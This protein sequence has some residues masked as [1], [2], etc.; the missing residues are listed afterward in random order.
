MD[1]PYGFKSRFS[2]HKDRLKN[3]S[4]LFYESVMGKQSDIN[5]GTDMQA[6]SSG[7]C[8]LFCVIEN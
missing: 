5:I 2:H 1:S 4:F 7:R 6:T 8:P 3:R